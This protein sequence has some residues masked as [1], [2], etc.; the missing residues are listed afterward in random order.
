MKHSPSNLRRRIYLK[1]I[2]LRGKRL[3]IVTVLGYYSVVVYNPGQPGEVGYSIG[4]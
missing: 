4:P 1:F 3:D 2:T